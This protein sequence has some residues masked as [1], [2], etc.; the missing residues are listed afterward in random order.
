MVFASHHAGCPSTQGG[1]L[2]FAN[3]RND[4]SIRKSWWKLFKY[5][6]ALD[7]DTSLIDLAHLDCE[8]PR[9]S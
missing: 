3:D 9:S 5:P 7:M 8:E 1:T 2:V 6:S 4:I